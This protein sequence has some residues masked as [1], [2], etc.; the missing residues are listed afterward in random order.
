VA[1]VRWLPIPPAENHDAGIRVP[2]EMVRE[3]SGRKRGTGAVI[4]RKRI[5]NPKRLTIKDGEIRVPR[6]MKRRFYNPEG[7]LLAFLHG[8]VR[9]CLITLRQSEVRYHTKRGVTPFWDYIP[10]TSDIASLCGGPRWESAVD[11]NLSD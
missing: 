6:Q 7:L 4:Y 11:A 3:H 9:D 5:T 1:S 2:F 8:S 10:P